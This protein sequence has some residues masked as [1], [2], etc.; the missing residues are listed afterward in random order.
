MS[1]IIIVD[2]FLCPAYQ[3]LIENYFFGPAVEWTE[4]DDIA[5]GDSGG[6]E[7]LGNK[8]RGWHHIMCG[9]NKPFPD[10]STPA[11][12]LIVPMVLE[13]FDMCG[14][15]VDDIHVSRAF[16]TD[17]H[18]DRLE[19]IHVDLHSPHHVCLYYPH[20]IDGD[21]IFYEEKW[22]DVTMET[23]PTTEFHEF[24][25]VSPKKG[26]AVIFDGTRFHSAFRSAVKDRVVINTNAFVS[27]K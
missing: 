23:Q 17:P 10:G 22:P 3:H 7:H 4:I 14:Y 1:D 13:A 21:T 18:E 27:Y 11:F 2:D 25:R 5:M 16:K 26:R 15:R 8:R 9:P 20:D 12:N 6:L 24:R 19:F